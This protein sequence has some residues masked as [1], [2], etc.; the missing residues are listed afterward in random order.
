MHQNFLEVPQFIVLQEWGH[1]EIVKILT[2]LTD[3]PNAPNIHGDTPIY[4][5]AWN[6]HSEIV[7]ILVPLTDIPNAPNE[8][9]E[10]GRIDKVIFVVSRNA[11]FIM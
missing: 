5:A 11:P 3:N 8:N 7:E 2:P 6:G 1:T 9:G 4:W 10:Q